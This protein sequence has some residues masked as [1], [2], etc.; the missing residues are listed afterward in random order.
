MPVLFTESLRGVHRPPFPIRTISTKGSAAVQYS[1]Q[2]NSYNV[3]R[4]LVDSVSSGDYALIGT[5]LDHTGTKVAT[6][7]ANRLREKGVKPI[8]FSLT[9][10]GY[11]FIGRFYDKKEME[12]FKTL[13]RLTRKVSSYFSEK[14]PDA[15][16]TGLS[17]AIAVAKVAKSPEKFKVS[18]LTKR[19]NT[20]LAITKGMLK[21]KSAG[22]GMKHLQKVY[23]GGLIEYPRVD[24]D[25][26][27]EKPFEVYAHSPLTA[28]GYTDFLISPMTEKELEELGAED[29]ET[30]PMTFETIPLYLS[31]ERVVTPSMV[32]RQM[33]RIEKVFNDDL[34]VKDGYQTYVNDCI[35]VADEVEEEYK[36]LLWELS[37]RARKEKIRV[38][39]IKE[40]KLLREWLESLYQRQL[41]LEKGKDE[42]GVVEKLDSRLKKTNKTGESEEAKVSKCPENFEDS[43]ELGEWGYSF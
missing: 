38:E 40:E 21:G 19:T 30:I 43:Q 4:G 26:I 33:A 37:P 2:S 25:L 23:A 31:V 12:A 16:A 18:G 32:S 9:A 7:I 20:A 15:P 11:A 36:R 28:T 39:R 29:E 42:V 17:T 35:A 27:M 13:D 8:R 10:G 1:M 34:T 41:E 14:Y 3:V 5:D 6:V 22:S 24:N